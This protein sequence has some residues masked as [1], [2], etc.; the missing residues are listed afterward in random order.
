MENT[1]GGK[2]ISMKDTLRNWL[3]ALKKEAELGN[4]DAMGILACMYRDSVG[5]EKD[6]TKAEYYAEQERNAPPFELPHD[7]DTNP[8]LKP[9]VEV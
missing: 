9:S 8:W 3:P 7:D 4:P 2:T 5:V 1:E 6:L